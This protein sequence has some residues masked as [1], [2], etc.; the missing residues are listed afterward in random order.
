MMEAPSA[1][2]SEAVGPVETQPAIASD[3]AMTR[4]PT[5]LRMSAIR[6]YQRPRKR[7]HRSYDE[8]MSA[9]GI[10]SAIPRRGLEESIRQCDR[11][12]MSSVIGLV[13]VHRAAIAV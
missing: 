5:A 1:A 2:A 8:L 7:P 9:A 4:S 13:A 6:I 10:R 12:D 11:V 3:A